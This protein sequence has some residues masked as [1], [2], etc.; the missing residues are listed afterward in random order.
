MHQI[1]VANPTVHTMQLQLVG[2]CGSA[3]R[4]NVKRACLRRA[5][6]SAAFALWHLASCAAGRQALQ[7]HARELAACALSE[8]VQSNNVIVLLGRLS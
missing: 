3:A 2:T 1:L 8:H 5:A 7:A 4:S 6:E